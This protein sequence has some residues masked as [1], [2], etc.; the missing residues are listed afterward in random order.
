MSG[1]TGD[2]FDVLSGE[3]TALRRSVEHY[4][5]T[6]LSKTEAADLNKSLV[7]A[8]GRMEKAARD[9]PRAL[10]SAFGTDRAQMADETIEATTQAAERVLKDVREQLHAERL[11]FAQAAGEARRAV[12]LSFGGVWVWGAALLCAGALVGAL[13]AIFVGEAKTAFDFGDNPERYC[14]FAGGQEGQLQDGS[15]YCAFWYD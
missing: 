7:Q 4:G 1:A 2:L 13:A 8:V 14:R 6:T 10:V 15:E 11:V 12:W 9:A 3:L 5:G